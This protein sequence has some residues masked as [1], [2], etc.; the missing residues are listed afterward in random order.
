MIP[1]AADPNA[2]VEGCWDTYV[3]VT[4]FGPASAYWRTD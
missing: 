3:S 2:A 4:K 1:Y